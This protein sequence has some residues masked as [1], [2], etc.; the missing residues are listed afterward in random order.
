MHYT[1]LLN[2]KYWEGC[3][4]LWYRHVVTIQEKENRRYK[5]Y[6]DGSVIVV[7]VS[8]V[9]LFLYSYHMPVP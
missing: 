3:S 6:Y 7:L 8:S 4:N 5:H 2:N 9:F 1:E